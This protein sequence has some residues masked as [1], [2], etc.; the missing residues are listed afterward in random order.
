MK[1]YVFYMD[2]SYGG[3]LV[4]YVRTNETGL[5]KL[6]FVKRDAFA[7]GFMVWARVNCYGKAS[8]FFINKGVKVNAK[9]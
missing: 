5:N 9:Y 7:P 2:D 1:L 4:C 3:R 8:L 6:E